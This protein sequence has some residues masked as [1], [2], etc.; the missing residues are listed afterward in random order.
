MNPA[1][2]S[3]KLGM[4]VGIVVPVVAFFFFYFYYIGDFGNPAYYFDYIFRMNIFTKMVSLSLIPNLV[5]FFFFIQRDR[6]Y[7]ARG[8]LGATFLFGFVMLLLF[9]LH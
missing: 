8:V 9:L 6:L 2:N 3:V 7:S 1:N 4:V 5:A